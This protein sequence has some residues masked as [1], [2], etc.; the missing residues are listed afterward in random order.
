MVSLVSASLALDK[1]AFMQQLQ[2]HQS[3]TMIIFLFC[4]SGPPEE[5]W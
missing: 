1:Q 2:L 3:S 4:Q 5:E